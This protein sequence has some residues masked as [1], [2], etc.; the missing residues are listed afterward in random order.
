M[1]SLSSNTGLATLGDSLPVENI[2]SRVFIDKKL[3]LLGEYHSFMDTRPTSLELCRYVISDSKKSAL[4]LTRVQEA[5]TPVQW[6]RIEHLFP[7]GANNKKKL[8][9]IIRKIATETSSQNVYVSISRRLLKVAS[10]TQLRP[11][12]VEC[13]GEIKEAIRNSGSSLLVLPTGAGKTR[14]AMEAIRGCI[15]SSTSPIHVLWIVH[16]IELCDQAEHAFEKTW[17]AERVV[18]GNSNLWLNKVFDSGITPIKE[19]YEDGCP[20]FTIATPDSVYSWGNDPPCH[21]NLIVVD[22]AHHGIN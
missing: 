12:Q 19:F 5:S 15:D 13:V 7:P 4:L 6:I 11:Y 8:D 22:E 20:S 1:Q 17:T 3:G 21:F 14:T 2:L 9:S 10:P 18:S 16:K